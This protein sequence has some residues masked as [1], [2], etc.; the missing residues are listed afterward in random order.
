MNTTISESFHLSFHSCF[1]Q[2]GSERVNMMFIALHTSVDGTGTYQ[3]GLRLQWVLTFLWAFRQSGLMDRFD[4]SFSQL[5][6]PLPLSKCHQIWCLVHSIYTPYLYKELPLEGNLRELNK[7]KTAICILCAGY[8][9]DV[10]HVHV[11][12]II[13][14]Y[15]ILLFFNLFFT[16][17]Q[18]SRHSPTPFQ[19]SR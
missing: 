19:G 11:H 14:I 17:K 9:L 8:L 10:V 7:K 4:P 18:F 3:S 12:T 13:W 1:S 5:S 15:F 2:I 16:F 6:C